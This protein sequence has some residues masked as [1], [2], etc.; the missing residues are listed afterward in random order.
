MAVWQSVTLMWRQPSSGAN[1]M[2]R[3]G[4]R[5]HWARTRNR[6]GPASR[7]QR[8]R[9][10][11]LGD[12]LL[13]GLVQ[14]PQRAVRIARPHVDREH[15]FHRRYEGAVG[16]RRDDPALPVMRLETVFL[17]VRPIV[18][19]LARSTMPTSTTLFSNSRSVR[20]ARPLGG[21]EQAGAI[22][23]TDDRIGALLALLACRL[24]LCLDRLHRCSRWL[25]PNVAIPRARSL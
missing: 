24:D 3:F 15:I 25:L 22:Y 14:V 2:N 18:E 4:W 12:K 11:R 7:L 1:G 17:T 9:H 20:R 23:H 10:A 8:D 5:C 13:G 19:S 16:L 21:L 6:H